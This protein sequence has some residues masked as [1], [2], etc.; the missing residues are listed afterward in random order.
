[1]NKSRQGE[2]F[3]LKRLQDE[4]WKFAELE[5]S[6]N[7]CWILEKNGRVIKIQIKIGSTLK[8]FKRLAEKDMNYLILTNLVDIYPIPME[9][10]K[11]SANSPKNLKK[12]KNRLNLLDKSKKELLWAVNDCGILFGELDS[13][14][15][16][17][18]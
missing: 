18:H 13:A 17:F 8:S 15:P 3:V 10:L 2:L 11:V 9:L 5:N 4:G 14:Y 7:D 16:F 1:M 12:V 6:L